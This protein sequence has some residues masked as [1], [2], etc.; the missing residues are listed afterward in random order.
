MKL[1][2]TS[3]AFVIAV[4]FHLLMAVLLWGMMRWETPEPPSQREERFGLRLD[5]GESPNEPLEASE[6]P[7]PSKRTKA[8][9]RVPAIPQTDTTEKSDH[10]PAQSEKKPFTPA[11][12]EQLPRSILHHYG[13]EFFELSAGEQHYIIDHLERIVKINNIV[14]TRLLH[15]RL[16]HEID[17]DDANVVEFTLHPDGT[18]SDLRLEKNRVGALLDE[19]TLQTIPL[20]QSRYPKP[21]QP[22]LIRI[23]VRIVLR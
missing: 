4:T 15:A 6:A 13:E 11:E 7:P 1:R 17:P 14:G 3:R 20:A 23:R 18:I 2:R 19:L 16:D 12:E 21:D 8:P 5:E 9:L 10:P 22:T